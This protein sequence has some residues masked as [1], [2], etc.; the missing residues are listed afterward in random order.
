MFNHKL[1]LREKMQ[2]SWLIQRLH[3]PQYFERKDKDGNVVKIDNPFSFGGGLINGGLSKEAMALL[4]EIFS[5]DYMGSAEFEFG[6]VPAALQFL[7]E[8]SEAKNLVTGVVEKSVYYLCPREYE[9]EVQNRISIFKKGGKGV[10]MPMTKEHVGLSDYFSR[11]DSYAKRNLG[12]LEIDNGYAFFVDEEM[13]T[14][15]CTVLGVKVR[16]PEVFYNR[17]GVLRRGWYWQLQWTGDA[18]PAPVGPFATKEE[19][20]MDF[21]T[22]PD[23]S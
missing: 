16:I 18:T 2:N 22:A 12:W 9:K 7:A 4:R 14:K 21:E 6:A 3:K 5:F 17:G 10:K 13:F 20:R 23:K 11:D 19:A 15:F 1:F 8:Q